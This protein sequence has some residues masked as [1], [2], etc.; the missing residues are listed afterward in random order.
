MVISSHPSVVFQ[1]HSG[2]KKT[3][4]DAIYDLQVGH[5]SLITDHLRISRHIQPGHRVQLSSDEMLSGRS[6]EGLAK[7]FRFVGLAGLA[8]VHK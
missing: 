6:G 8:V 4:W 2:E 5:R 3:D 7:S 1:I